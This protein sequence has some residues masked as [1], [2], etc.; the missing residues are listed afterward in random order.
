MKTEISTK[1]EGVITIHKEGEIIGI[2]YNDMA[3]RSKRLFWVKEMDD[4]EIA[5][6]LSAKDCL[7]TGT[8]L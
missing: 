8:T 2:I 7:S 4:E 5:D 6:L 3:T 1:K